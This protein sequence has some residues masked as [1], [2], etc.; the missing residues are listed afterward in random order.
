MQEWLEVWRPRLAP[1]GE[2]HVFVNLRGKPMAI[3]TMT[4]TIKYITYRL[5]GVAVTPHLIRDIWASSYLAD[6]GDI[7]GAAHRLGDKPETVLTHYAHILEARANARANT[8]LRGHLTGHSG[9]EPPLPTP[10]ASA[11]S[12]HNVRP[13]GHRYGKELG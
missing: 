9:G 2:R 11:S 8:W 6:T 10:P 1:A 12:I 4:Q 7:M 3:F 5:T 13:A